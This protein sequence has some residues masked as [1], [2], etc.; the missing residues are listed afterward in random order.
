MGNDELIGSNTASPMRS[1]QRMSLEQCLSFSIK[2]WL[3]QEM[4][5]GGFEDFYIRYVLNVLQQGFD[6]PE[7]VD[8][9]FGNVSRK[10]RHGRKADKKKVKNIGHNEQKVAM[11]ELLGRF[12]N[13]SCC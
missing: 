4:E 10:L 5:H 2:N 8:S 12:A 6:E 11:K 3:S 13:V 1:I 7:L 9:E